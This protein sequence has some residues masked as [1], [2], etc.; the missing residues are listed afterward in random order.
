MYLICNNFFK[1]MNRREF[2]TVASGALATTLSPAISIAGENAVTIDDY[3]FTPDGI[4]ALIGPKLVDLDVGLLHPDTGGATAGFYASLDTSHGTPFG[5]PWKRVYKNYIRDR[6]VHDTDRGTL[7]LIA[8]H[9]MIH[10][11]T[12]EQMTKAYSVTKNLW[13]QRPELR[14]QN[15]AQPSLTLE[16]E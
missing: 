12:V 13:D 4:N 3:N 1:D 6:S 5:D 15:T 7:I 9:V 10:A 2:L 8:R 16:L 14:F 11:V